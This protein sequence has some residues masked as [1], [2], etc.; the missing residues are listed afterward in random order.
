[1]KKCLSLLLL[2]I[3]GLLNTLQAQV[4]F[5]VSQKRVSPTEIDVTFKA[6]IAKGWH[7]Y[8][9][10]IPDGGPTAAR[11]G[12]D[13]ADGAEPLGALKPGPGV[14]SMHDDVFE[15]QLSFFENT[16]TFTQRIKLTKKDYKLKAYLEW[17]A[18][19]DQNC[20]PPSTTEVTVSGSDGPTGEAA[21]AA[22]AE[23]AHK[24][25]PDPTMRI[26]GWA[27]PQS[28]QLHWPMP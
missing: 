16:A 12:V 1:M 28:I 25:E 2:T 13:K 15:M 8:S 27:P 17:G 11:F 19:N 22:A 10:N 6:K 26:A 3:A 20:L 23:M 18:C 5:S 21:K 14:K 7:V 24:T 4:S 9:T